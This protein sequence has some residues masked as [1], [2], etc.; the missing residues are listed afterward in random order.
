MKFSVLLPTRNRLF[1]LKYA[2]ASV[3]KQDYE[4]W[5]IIISDNDSQENISGYVKSLNDSRIKYHRT[6]CFVSVT[7]NWNNAMNQCKGDYVIML[8]DDDIL[9]SGYFSTMIKLLAK[10]NNPNMIYANAYIY[11]YPGVI[12]SCP[13]GH[14]MTCKHYSLFN[15]ATEPLWLSKEMARH[16]VKGHLNFKAHFGT[17]MQFILIKKDAI[18]RVRVNNQFFHSPYPDVY[19]MCKLMLEIEDILIYPIESVVIGVTPKSTGNFLVNNNE[20][21]GME[22][23]NNTNEYFSLMNALSTVILPGSYSLTCWLVSMETLRLLSKKECN[24]KINYQRYRLLQ[25]E[26]A[27]KNFFHSKKLAHNRALKKIFHLISLKEKFAFFS[28]C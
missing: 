4:N 20:E 6:D 24:L 26:I 13:D 16:L 17:N 14:L 7:E 2:V 11:S 12:P 27:I 23:L 1:Y 25:I 18:D 3:L 5:E 19:A 10:F 22:F 9:L 28:L 15:N 8:G 21:K